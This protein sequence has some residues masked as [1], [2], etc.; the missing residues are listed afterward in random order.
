MFLSATQESK[1][2]KYI[3]CI[4]HPSV[5]TNKN[6]KCLVNNGSKGM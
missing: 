3:D 4:E 1:F 5:N 2:S 6:I